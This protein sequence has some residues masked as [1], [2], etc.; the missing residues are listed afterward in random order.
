ML[1]RN[2]MHLIK[3]RALLRVVIARLELLWHRDAVLIGKLLQ[4]F[5]ERQPFDHF[6]K[7]KNV[8][9]RI[10]AEA[11]EILMLLGYRK[12]RCF[13]V[14]EGTETGVPVTHAPQPHI[15]G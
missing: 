2:L 13:L 15:V 9:L 4:G 10:A 11:A 14:V 3:R 5:E 12:R 7:L 8:A 6:D 1:Q